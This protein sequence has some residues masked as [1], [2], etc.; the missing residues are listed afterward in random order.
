MMLVI[1]TNTRK[2]CMSWPTPVKYELSE[3]RE[4]L[5]VPSLV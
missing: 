2:G 3:L 5:T 4:L 1:N